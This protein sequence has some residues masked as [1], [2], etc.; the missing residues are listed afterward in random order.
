MPAEHIERQAG[1]S[2]QQGPMYAPIPQQSRPQPLRPQQAQFDMQQGYNAPAPVQAHHIQNQ[3][4]FNAPAQVQTQHPVQTQHLQT[5]VL[6]SGQ[7]VY[8]NAPPPQYGY[9]TVQYHPHSQQHHIVHQQ[10]PGGVGPH[11]GEQQYISVVPIQNAGGHV[12]GMGPVQGIGPGG[13]YAYWQPDGQHGVPQTLTIVNPHA[14]G[15]GAGGVPVAVA[16][17]GNSQSEP[18]RNQQGNSQGGRGKEK[19]G[20]GRRGG[21]PQSRRGGGESKNQNSTSGSPLL[22]DFKSKKNRDWKIYEIKGT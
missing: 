1:E 17:V 11:G 14:H 3:P 6:P 7:T 19:G 22:D 8:V 12:Q 15:P 4:R 20:K 21:Q 5:Q 18:P 2:R 13:T 10:V 16:R 9:A